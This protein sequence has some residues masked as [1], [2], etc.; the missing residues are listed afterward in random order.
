MAIDKRFCPPD[1]MWLSP[2]EEEQN[3]QLFKSPHHC[4]RYA[5]ELV[6]GDAHPEIFRFEKC[7]ES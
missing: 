1:C 5:R 2:T 7:D 6:H 3:A 4:G